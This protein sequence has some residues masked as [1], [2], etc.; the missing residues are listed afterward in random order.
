LLGRVQAINGA[1]I[2]VLG[3][4]LLALCVYGFLALS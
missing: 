4:A 1:M 2:V 3:F